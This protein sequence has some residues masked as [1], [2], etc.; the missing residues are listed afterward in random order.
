MRV[1]GM[2]VVLQQTRPHGQLAVPFQLP[3]L[4]GII[5]GPPQIEHMRRMLE[6]PSGGST[7][8]ACQQCR[9]EASVACG[10][11]S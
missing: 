9:A 10:S 3:L 5:T 2:R 4:N 11:L 8:C 6:R 7:D 1:E